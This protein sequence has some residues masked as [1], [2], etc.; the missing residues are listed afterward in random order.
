MMSW[1]LILMVICILFTLS[2]FVLCWIFKD[3]PPKI[4]SLRGWHVFITGGTKGI[5]LALAR[6]AVRQGA[7]VTVLARQ[8]QLID[9][10]VLE[11]SELADSCQK[12]IVK[13]YQCDMTSDY[14]KIAQV[15]HKAEQDI[16]PI[17]VLINNVGGAMQGIIEEMGIEVFQQQISL[18]YISAV[19]A[20]K[21]ALH[22]IKNSRR[23]EGSRIVFVSSQAG[24]V[25]LYGYTAYSP[26]KFALRGFAEALQMELRPHNAWVTVAYPPNTNTEG[27]VEEWKTT[28]VATKLITGGDEVMEPTVVAKEIFRSI[29]CGKFQCLFGVSGEMLGNLCCGMTPVRST[30]E[31]IHQAFFTGI[32][33]IISLCY[34]KHFNRVVLQTMLVK[35]KT[36][37]GKEVELDIDASDLVERIKEKIEEKEGI[38]PAQQRLIH[39]GKQMS[40]GK[41]AAEYKITGGAVLHLVLALR[42][43]SL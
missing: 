25:G 37:T 14:D 4:H 32:Y 21:A 1:T 27:F 2:L 9:A 11:L 38:P 3:Q 22:S 17:D 41:T 30:A 15:V 43:G 7:H 8:Q 42:G 39:A 19:S 29:T 40:E 26:C 5:G 33:R 6:E 23:V 12:Q 16:G 20:T 28:P 35:V 10:V 31:L 34:L 36:L 24:Q 13:G 18:N